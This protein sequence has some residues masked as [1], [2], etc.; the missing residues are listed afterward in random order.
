LKKIR[1][2]F[3]FHLKHS[4]GV[5]FLI[6]GIFLIKNEKKEFLSRIPYSG[7]ARPNNGTFFPPFYKGFHFLDVETKTK[8]SLELRVR[9]LRTKTNITLKFK[10][11][12]N[13]NHPLIKN[14]NQ[15]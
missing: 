4:Q 6:L 12:Q 8:G 9:E 13:R 1:I 15:N 3:Q 7:A 14:Q 11:N 5:H 2:H 10:K